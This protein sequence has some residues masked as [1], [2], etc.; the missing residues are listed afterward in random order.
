[1]RNGT[2]F[3]GYAFRC[4][5]GPRLLPGCMRNGK[6]GESDMKEAQNE[7]KMIH[8]ADE[9]AHHSMQKGH[10]HLPSPAF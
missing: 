10:E 1:M 9:A 5:S 8:D 3:P 4:G 6:D 7:E 2:V